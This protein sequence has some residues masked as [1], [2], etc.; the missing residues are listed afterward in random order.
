MN[1]LVVFHVTSYFHCFGKIVDSRELLATDTV[2]VM[3][4]SYSATACFL[5]EK[6]NST[7][8]DVEYCMTSL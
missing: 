3:H 8:L 7:Q 5:F 1:R 4:A 2:N 6:G